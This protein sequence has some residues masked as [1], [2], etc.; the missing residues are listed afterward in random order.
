[1]RVC[2]FSNARQHLSSVLNE[3]QLPGTA[4]ITRKDGSRF[5]IMPDNPQ[6]SPLDVPGVQTD[7]TREDIIKAIRESRERL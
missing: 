2:T 7:I 5:T 6:R 3:A 4:Y 1:M